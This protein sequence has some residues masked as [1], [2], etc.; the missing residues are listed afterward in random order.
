MELPAAAATESIRLLPANERVLASRSPAG[1]AVERIVRDVAKTEMPVLILGESGTG[2]EVTAQLIHRLSAR[3]SGPFVRCVCSSLGAESLAK[4][5]RRTNDGSR[6][7]AGVSGA[8]LFLDGVSELRTSCQQKLLQWLPEDAGGE[9]GGNHHARIISSASNHFKAEVG[10]GHF[11]EELYY[12][13]NGISIQLPR[14]N[15]R[16]EDILPF[17][18]LFLARFSR[19]FG[20]GK[21]TLSPGVLQALLECSWPGNIRQLKNVVKRIVVL[22]DEELAM[23][24]VQS[25]A[26]TPG[27]L[28]NTPEM[29]SL[30]ESARTAARKAEN[31]LILKALDRT[32]WNRKRAAKELGISYKALLYKLKQIGLDPFTGPQ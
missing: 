1:Q 16:K 2:K 22:G 13:L 9:N 28:K 23:A 24:D 27:P 8:T 21:P 3:R 32:R 4:L 10:A 18:D 29:L 31:Q 26:A 12:R 15:Q 5:L 20:K 7:S 14:L 25:T 6:S 11:R 30:K 17:A 19:Q